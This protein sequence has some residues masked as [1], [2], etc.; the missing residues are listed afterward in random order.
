MMRCRRP[1]CPGPGEIVDGYCDQC[2]FAPSPS[3]PGATGPTAE[4]FPTT[5]TS[6]S[7]SPT[8]R[9]TGVTARG[10]RGNLGE[11]LVDVPPVPY[12]DPAD[13]VLPPDKQLPERRRFCW[14]CE[15]PVGRSREGR[16]GA[17]EG[18]CSNCGTRFSFTPKLCPG[19]LVVSR[20]QVVGCLAHGGLGWVYLAVDHNLEDKPIVLK[21]LLD[22]GDES[23]MTAAIAERHFLIEVDHPN[24]V[25]IIDFV[26]HA[27][28]SYIV[29][30]YVGG[31]SLKDLRQDG[32]NGVAAPLPVGVA[33]AYS[34]AI[35]PA[36]GYLH[37]YGLVYCDFKPDNVIQ[38]EE[39]VKLIDLGGVRHV[40]DLTGDIYGTVGYQAPEVSDVGPSASSDLYTVARTLAVLCFDF[41]GFQDPAHHATTLPERAEV[42]VL[43]RYESLY[44][45]LV[46]GTHPDPAS[47][48]QSADEMHDQLLGV[49]REVLALDGAEPTPMSS[50]LFTPELLADRDHPD[51]RNLPLPK[52]D[53]DDP[54]ATV[55][56]S[57]ASAA[58]DQLL[59][60]LRAAPDSPE[61]HYRTALAHLE[62]GDVDEAARILDEADPANWRTTWWQ[63]VERLAA[64]DPGAA[65]TSF[66]T[67]VRGLPGELAPKLALATAIETDLHLPDD[68]AR[69]SGAPDDH[70]AE[71]AR[72]YEIVARTDPGHASA[73]FGLARLCEAYADRRAAATALAR[74]PTTAVSSTPAQVA[75]CRVLTSTI[76]GQPPELA[77]LLDASSLVDRLDCEPSTRA[78][79]RLDLLRAGLDL[80]DRG[81]AAPDATIQ[82]GGVPLTESAL[83]LEVERTYRSLAAHAPSPNER[84]ALI[85]EANR[86]RPRSLV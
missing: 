25:K 18:F 35:L 3:D 56:A 38:S 84:F 44:W 17:T 16:P 46:K 36:L 21:G 73:C 13:L 52:V 31:K 64:G 29:M 74:I 34:L 47:R 19:D 27:G 11:G 57:L 70:V 76:R 65:R 67:L 28:A 60:A 45:F 66:A 63:G 22:S 80:L 24:I 85:D 30:E 54:G 26:E 43:A 39:Q 50:M 68:P 8:S 6:A 4:P 41:K 75:R 72:Y 12:R 69:W 79:A 1:G 78:S 7:H 58:T 62:A 32:R 83:R 53:P 59:A 61:I 48:F 71:A 14:K 2:G 5:P 55:L 10:G 20:Y 49:L 40:D 37:A 77:D 15:H 23:A 86:A 33:I 81:G 51:W 42:P 9:T 82:I